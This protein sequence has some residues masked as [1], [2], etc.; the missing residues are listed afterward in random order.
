MTPFAEG[1]YLTGYEA[2]HKTVDVRWIFT[3]KGFRYHLR[4]P[5]QTVQAHLLVPSGKAPKALRV[6]GREMGFTLSTVGESRYVDAVV[7]PQDGVADFE[8][9]Y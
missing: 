3:E 1:R 4:S 2:A 9:F 8:V 7:T 6:N 5:A